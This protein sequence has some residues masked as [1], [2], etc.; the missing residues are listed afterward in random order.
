[1]ADPIDTV[2]VRGQHEFSRHDIPNPVQIE[3]NDDMILSKL[4]K[5]KNT[6]YKLHI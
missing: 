2:I 1:M 5:Y 6:Y 3:I 4:K